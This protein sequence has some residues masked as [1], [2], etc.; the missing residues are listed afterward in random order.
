MNDAELFDQVL[1]KYDLGP[2]FTPSHWPQEQIEG[3]ERYLARA[4]TIVSLACP[5]FDGV[6][7]IYVD[8]VENSEFNAW[9]TTFSDRYFIGINL[10]LLRASFKTA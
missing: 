2:R 1:T 7:T 3:V 5:H 8:C 4:R 6:P 10:G 9:A